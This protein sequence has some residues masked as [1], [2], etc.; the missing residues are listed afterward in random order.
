[1]IPSCS[2]SCHLVTCFWELPSGMNH[3]LFSL[4]L[5]VIVSKNLIIIALALRREAFIT[6]KVLF[7]QNV[8][9][10]SQLTKTCVIYV[11]FDKGYKKISPPLK[12]PEFATL[13][14]RFVSTFITLVLNEFIFSSLQVPT[15]QSKK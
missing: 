3:Y 15:W 5:A 4:Y 13:A 8:D 2:E 1:M 7:R 10:I 9:T 14:C 6:F 12:I 11:S